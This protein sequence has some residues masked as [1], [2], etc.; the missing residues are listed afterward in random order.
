MTFMSNERRRAMRA[1]W[2]LDVH[3]LCVHVVVSLD[4]GRKSSKRVVHLDYPYAHCWVLLQLLRTIYCF[5]SPLLVFR[6][7]SHAGGPG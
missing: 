5:F 6:L 4:H 3:I 2:F 7:S 1:W